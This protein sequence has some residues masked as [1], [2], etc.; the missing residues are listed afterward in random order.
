M[1][2]CTCWGR[3]G[4]IGGVDC[5]SANKF[6]GLSVQFLVRPGFRKLVFANFY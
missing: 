1:G 5:M 3:F 2:G 6:G 4:V